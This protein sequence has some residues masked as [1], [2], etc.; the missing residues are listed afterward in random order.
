MPVTAAAE[1]PAESVNEPDDEET[2]KLDESVLPSVTVY[3]NISETLP[4][5]L[6]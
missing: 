1:P 3:W 5:P 6:E 2:D 4:E